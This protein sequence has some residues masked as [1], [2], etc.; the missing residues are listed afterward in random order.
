MPSTEPP[1]STRSSFA[2]CLLTSM[3][4][5]FF[6]AV[7]TVITGGYFLTLLAAFAGIMAFTG[8]HY[9]LWGWMMAP[10]PPDE[11]DEE[12]KSEPDARIRGDRSAEGWP[13]PDSDRFTRF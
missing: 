7:L 6:L 5:L 8:V 1:S 2:S 12:E 10:K 3:F 4:I 11:P 9:L 13:L